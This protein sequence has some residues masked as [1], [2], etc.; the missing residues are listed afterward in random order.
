MPSIQKVTSHAPCPAC[1][2]E[3]DVTFTLWANRERM[4]LSRYFSCKSCG[5]SESRDR[6]NLTGEALAMFRNQ[7]GLSRIIV[8]EAPDD[9]ST[10]LSL[11]ENVLSLDRQRIE[12]IASAHPCGLEL[13]RGPEPVITELHKIL[14]ESGYIVSM[15]KCN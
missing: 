11:P 2:T 8:K 15:E 6:R 7:H 3:G 14:L 9:W 4:R 1:G 12:E 13:A 10:A 5:H